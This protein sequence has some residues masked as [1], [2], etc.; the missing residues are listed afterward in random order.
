METPLGLG[1]L[2]DTICYNAM[3][4]LNHNML[5]S[6]NGESFKRYC[7]THH[8]YNN[9]DDE[10]FNILSSTLLDGTTWN[11]IERNGWESTLMRYLSFGGLP[12]KDR[13]VTKWR[14]T[15]AYDFVFRYE[16]DDLRAQAT[17]IV[18][19]GCKNLPTNFVVQWAVYR[20]PDYERQADRLGDLPCELLHRIDKPLILHT[21]K[22]PN[23]IPHAQAL[24]GLLKSYIVNYLHERTHQRRHIT[25]FDEICVEIRLDNLQR[26]L[27]EPDHRSL[28]E[29][30]LAAIATQSESCSLI[31]LPPCLEELEALEYDDPVQLS[32]EVHIEGVSL[33]LSEEAIDAG[34]A[35]AARLLSKNFHLK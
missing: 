15:K 34:A 17:Y 24:Q 28:Y 32:W 30:I 14:K 25:S 13:G 22:I 19:P 7:R 11:I 2:A 35:A 27:L 10:T 21:S 1:F 29:K 23:T 16:D 31:P 4:D 3:N 33:R 12:S 8:R 18:P 9:P 20:S 26:M 6:I 5:F